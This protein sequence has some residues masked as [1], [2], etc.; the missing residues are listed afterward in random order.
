MQGGGEPVELCE[1]GTIGVRTGDRWVPA[2]GERTQMLL[3]G[4]SLN[5]HRSLTTESLIEKVWPMSGQPT[6]ARQ[7]LANMIA[8]LRAHHGDDFIETDGA[9]YRLGDRVRSDRQRFETEVIEADGALRTDP[10]EALAL[11]ERAERRWRG[12]PWGAIEAPDEVLVDRTRLEELA[13]D[14]RRV[15]AIAL[16]TLG[17]SS[18][19]IPQLEASVAHRP[20]DE[21]A[22]MALAGAHAHVGD[23]VDALRTLRRARVAMA[24]AGLDLGAAASELEHRLLAGSDSPES[25]GLSEL[26]RESTPLIGRG[27]V[28]AHV[29]GL[30]AE[31]GLVTVFGPAGVGKTRVATAVARQC[32]DRNSAFIDLSPVR[33]TGRIPMVLTAALGVNVPLGVEPL[34]ALVASLRDAAD[35][36][37]LDNCEQVVEAVTE[38]VSRLVERCP[39]LRIL[40]TSRE[41]LGIEPERVVVIEPLDTGSDGDAV[42][43][44]FDRARRTGVVLDTDEWRSSVAELCASLDGLPLC[45]ELAAGRAAVLSPTEIQE[46]LGDRFTML[47]S[48]DDTDQRTSLRSAME[49]SW[50]LL[51]AEERRTMH[52]LS[53]FPS[54]ATVDAATHVLGL[55][56]WAMV[57]MA[58]RLSR[59]SLLN[60]ARQPHC[61]TRLEL[62]DTIRFFALED[63]EETGVLSSCRDAHLA[64]VDEYTAVVVGDRGTGQRLGDPL[65][66]LDAERHEIRAAL[67]HAASPGGDSALGVRICLRGYTWW[68][69]R[70]TGGEA[71]VRTVEL[72]ES[73]ELSPL[74]RVDAIAVTASL[75]RISGS[76]DGE[77]AEL[78]TLAYELLAGVDDPGD[79]ARLE[80]RLIEASFDDSDAGLGD[81]LRHLAPD[82]E[83]LTA[84]H[85]L[86]AWTVANQPERAPEVAAELARGSVGH[87][88]ACVAHARE[89]QG[90]AAIATGD[91]GSAQH[92]LA[93]AFEVFDAIDQTFCTIHWC[94][95][96]AWLL[97]EAGASDL[98]QDLLAQTEGVRQVQRRTRAGFEMQAIDGARRR[99]GNLPK[100]DRS[101]G[102]REVIARSSAALRRSEPVMTTART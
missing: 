78:V 74:D 20:L 88:D 12:D 53:V 6:T 49:W 45:I 90:L 27:P 92:H 51:S 62:L 17:R 32:P 38:V 85:L 41:R 87:A 91:L 82:D 29:G 22:W 101:A 4:L 25:A 34:D 60:V 56:R 52:H 71:V 68:R 13:D 81:R 55:D 76:T 44:F 14:A 59:K 61:A 24:E 97:A 46:G 16:A 65:A 75:S 8:R 10:E 94:E 47:S 93:E 89:L 15:R 73:A 2:R 26:P 98:A 33:E 54:G 42:E 11:I 58:E 23:R 35:L 86:A 21:P 18:E 84:M 57:E 31:H 7:S 36:L 3:A 64:W 30:L 19:A 79:R 37:V 99:L 80:I 9:A 102:V 67:D 28:I 63:A 50:D 39:D 83:T 72:L 70:S 5:R 95:S 77:I 66:H 48:G 43:L 100:P 40:V 96:V 69:G 1:L